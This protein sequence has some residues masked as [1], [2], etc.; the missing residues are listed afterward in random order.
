LTKEDERKQVAEHVK[1]Y[2]ARGGVI[3]H[4]P[5]GMITNRKDK[6]INRKPIASAYRVWRAPQF[7][8]VESESES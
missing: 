7:E 2:L 6:F 3:S 4:I 8:D 5:C 1:Q